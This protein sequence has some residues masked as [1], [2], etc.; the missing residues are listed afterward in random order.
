[1]PLLLL[2]LLAMLPVTRSGPVNVTPAPLWGGRGH[3]V[4][5]QLAW[6]RLS[7]EARRR[8]EPLLA[9]RSLADVSTWAD[10]VRSSRRETSPWHYVNMPIWAPR[11]EPERYC[12]DGACV[13]GAI[14]RFRARLGDP[15]LPAGERR[16]ALFFLVHFVQDLHQP[17]HAGDRGDRGGN[18]V[19]VTWQ[20][21]DVNLHAFWDTELVGLLADDED[22]LYRRIRARLAST[23]SEELSAW[24]GG[25]PASWAMESKELARTIAYRLPRDGVITTG[26]LNMAMPV[27]EVQM[28][29]A[30]V[31]LAILLEG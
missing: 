26:Y 22:G 14:E 23:T 16:E 25:D 8:L 11:Y 21:R 1:M 13:I 4:I 18:L 3:H 19:Q 9:G 5:G 30:V 10:S 24:R 20:G 27:A 15:R 6:A 31:R 17:L 7:P 28:A 2:G 12:P 29:R